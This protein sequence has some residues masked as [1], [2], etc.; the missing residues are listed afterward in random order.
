MGHGVR[1]LAARTPLPGLPRLSFQLQGCRVKG[2]PGFTSVSKQANA[3]LPNTTLPTSSSHCMWEELQN[4]GL[5]GVQQ[6]I[7]PLWAAG[8]PVLFFKREMERTPHGA[9]AACHS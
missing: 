2:T 4:K 5:P 6:W 7:L 1:C 8:A 3:A 9:N